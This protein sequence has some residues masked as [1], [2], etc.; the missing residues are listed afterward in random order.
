ML[1]APSSFNIHALRNKCFCVRCCASDAKNASL[2]CAISHIHV[3]IALQHIY[4]LLRR[5]WFI[6]RARQPV[7]KV[8]YFFER[9]VPNMS[10]RMYRR[11]FRM[12]RDTL[13]RIAA[14]LED[15]PLLFQNDQY[16]R[17]SHDKKIAMTCAYLGTQCPT[18]QYV[19]FW[20]GLSF[21]LHIHA[22]Y[23]YHNFISVIP[24]D[25]HT[26]LVLRK[27]LSCV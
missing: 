27:N 14:D 9:I 23:F 7:I 10:E 8:N 19:M 25:Y 6:F 11:Y 16:R 12:K 5:T 15:C 24:T 20:L 17:I 1:Y 13:A 2:Y 3:E 26:Y 18:I 21:Y 4:N 22:Q